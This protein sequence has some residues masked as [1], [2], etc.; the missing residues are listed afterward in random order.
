[1]TLVLVNP[2]RL[3]AT[4]TMKPHL[5][6]G[7]V[8][9]VCALTATPESSNAQA[10]KQPVLTVSYFG[11]FIGHPGFKAGINV[12]L[13]GRHKPGKRHSLLLGGGNVGAYYHKGNH[14][15]LFVEG[16][17]GYRFVT[18]GGFK[19]ETFLSAGYHRSFIDG[20]VYS[21]NAANEVT[22]KRGGRP[23]Y[24]AGFLADRRGETA[25]EQPCGLAY[26]SRVH[27]TNPT[28]LVHFTP[29]FH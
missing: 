17:L 9:L 25:K 26:P 7:L 1:M 23:E 14:T 4:R 29:L 28:Q 6:A 3:L 22:Q 10:P 15:G 2:C 11:E 18:R 8:L 13:A 5:L 12:P 19:L 20:P 21:V 24:H 16:E 27:D